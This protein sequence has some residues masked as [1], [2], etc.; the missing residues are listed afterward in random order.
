MFIL[1]GAD[2]V[3]KTTLAKRILE[4]PVMQH[5]GYTYAHLSRP[6]CGFDHYWD[7]IGM[8]N[9]HVVQDRFHMGELVYRS[10]LKQDTPLTPY[11]IRLID[12]QLRLIGAY[13]VIV[14]ATRDMIKARAKQR[15]EPLDVEQIIRINDAYQLDVTLQIDWAK[16]LYIDGDGAT[17][18][19]VDKLVE[20]YIARQDTIDAVSLRGKAG[21]FHGLR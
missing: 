18:F 13:T 4:R 6:P 5:R 19:M 2:L 12:A 15:A 9:R 16:K 20:E 8:M 14:I 1:E 17:D 11:M 10:V 3:G 21:H 7:Y